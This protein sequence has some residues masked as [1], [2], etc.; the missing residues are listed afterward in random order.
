MEF[1]WRM[2]EKRDEKR[3]EC[4]GGKGEGGR[5]KEKAVPLMFSAATRPKL[6]QRVC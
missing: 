3:E 6:T 4:N 1:R 2:Q 5:E